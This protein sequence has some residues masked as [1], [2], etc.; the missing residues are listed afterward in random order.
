MIPQVAF[1]PPPGFVVIPQVASE[2]APPPIGGGSGARFTEWKASR[3]ALTGDVLLAACVATP[4][5]GWVDDMRPFVDARTTA[6]TSASAERVVGVPVETREVE[7]GGHFY[8]RPVGAPP[9]SPR[10]GI[11]RT[12]VG[13]DRTDVVTCFVT[14]ATPK[15]VARGTAARGCDSSVLTARLE[16]GS[17]P[18]PPGIVLS[19]VTWAVH[20]PSAAVTWGVSLAFALGVVAVVSR[21]R[22][23]SRI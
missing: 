23:R 17:G 18:P 2:I 8:L 7:G 14:C 20:H 4:I 12:F 13:W 11:A 9:D 15:G 21:R 10:V 6:I 5:P 16:G 22:Q 3:S 19:A 1:E